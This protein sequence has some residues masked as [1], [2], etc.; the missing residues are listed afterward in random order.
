MYIQRPSSFKHGMMTET[1][2]LYFFF[3]SSLDD[4]D[5]H[6]GQ[7]F[8][9]SDTSVLIFL[10][11]PQLIWMKCSLLPQPIGLVKLMVN[12][13]CMI[14]IQERELFLHDLIKYTLNICLHSDTYMF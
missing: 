12:L 5:L 8:E 6:Y 3:S 7:L 4:L 1:R 14:N 9:K 10:Q 2:E 11:I 13:R